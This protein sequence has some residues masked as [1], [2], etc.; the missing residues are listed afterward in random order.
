[1]NMNSPTIFDK[2]KTNFLGVSIDV[3]SICLVKKEMTNLV[4]L[5][6][7]SYFIKITFEMSL[8]IMNF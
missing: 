4:T 2:I 8:Y 7:Y 1:M 6:L 5:S 3:W